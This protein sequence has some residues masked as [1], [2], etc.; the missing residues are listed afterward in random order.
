MASGA[1]KRTAVRLASYGALATPPFVLLVGWWPLN[2]L[3]TLLIA[4]VI[5]WLLEGRISM[6]KL[7]AAAALFIAGGAIVEFWWF[8]IL[9]CLSA[10]GYCRRPTPARA[11]LWIV[12]TGSLGVVNGNLWSMAAVPLAWGATYVD[13]RMP[14]RRSFFYLYYAGHLVVLAALVWALSRGTPRDASG[15]MGFTPRHVTE[16]AGCLNASATWL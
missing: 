13:L 9:A 1:V 2:V 15:E 7:A 8:G 6:S 16:Y 14:R 4:V 11:L 3:F 5:V 10:W 12:S